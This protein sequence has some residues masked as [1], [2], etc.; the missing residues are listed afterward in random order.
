MKKTLS[1]LVVLM[2]I[3]SVVFARRADNPG[4]AAGM[5]VVKN[6]TTFKLYYKGTQQM[7]VKV[8][9]FDAT[10]K[11]VF[12]EVLRKV[13]GFVR[14]YN[15]SNLPEGVYSIEI[16]DKDGRQVEKVNY[17][18]GKIEKLAHLLRV[19]GDEEKYLLTVSNKGNDAI[20]VKIFDDSNSIIYSHKED[21]KG[22]FAKIYNL[23][24]FSGKFKFEIT[25]EKGGTKSFG[26]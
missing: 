12:T 15:F 20:T 26:F 24:R 21:I 10:N 18:K 8:S 13:E 23:E 19:S 25:D 17:Q 22:D 16:A 6:G 3:S 5:A 1:V 9:I 14:P 4:A 2:V 11:I 7:D